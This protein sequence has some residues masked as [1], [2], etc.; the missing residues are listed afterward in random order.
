MLNPGFRLFLMTS[1]IGGATIKCI[2]QFCNKCETIL[3]YCLLVYFPVKLTGK[4]IPE[5]YS[6][7]SWNSRIL[8]TATEISIQY[9]SSS[10][11]GLAWF[12]SS[13]S[14]ALLLL[15]SLVSLFLT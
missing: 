10:L 13:T 12:L 8:S 4:K 6:G 1:Q 11:L 9:T 3:N 2:F 15:L 5:S 7:I 14:L